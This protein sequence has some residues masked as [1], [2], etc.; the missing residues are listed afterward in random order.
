MPE[1]QL[2]DYGSQARLS[3]LTAN[4]PDEQKTFRGEKKRFRLEREIL[5]S[6]DPFAQ[7]IAD[8]SAYVGE[9]IGVRMSHRL[10]A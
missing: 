7:A 6:R 1:A 3:R 10:G 8:P 9:V 4:Q 2:S 5:K